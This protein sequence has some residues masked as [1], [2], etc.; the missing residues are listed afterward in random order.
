MS[1]NIYTVGDSIGAG[2]GNV[3]GV[4]GCYA[5]NGMAPSAMGEH[6]AQALATAKQGDT[7]ILSAGYNGNINE[8]QL[9][10]WVQGLRDNGVKVAILA[11][12]TEWTAEEVATP[13]SY[14]SRLAAVTP[15]RNAALLRIAN[16]T[17]SGFVPDARRLSNALPNGE[18][19]PADYKPYVDAA[20]A[21]VEHQPTTLKAPA[22]APATADA[23]AATATPEAAAQQRDAVAAEGAGE[24]NIFEKII[25]WI[26]NL[27]K[28]M[29]GGDKAEPA[30]DTATPGS[31]P[32]NGEQPA[33]PEA[34]AQQNP[35]T[36]E[37][38]AQ[39]AA[40]APATN[41][42]AAEGAATTPPPAAARPPVAAAAR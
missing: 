36:P 21:V 8:T 29:F 17:G 11:L 3:A 15:E 40:A 16:A 1:G 26:V 14:A 35:I 22:A 10:T 7:V 23:P 33:A 20:V 19:H 13:N 27:F 24:K 9:R 25:E 41:A 28:G 37:V 30:A 18:I 2:C 4:A 32:A 31:T 39:A 42:T 6:F 5:T 12:R 38:A 34:P